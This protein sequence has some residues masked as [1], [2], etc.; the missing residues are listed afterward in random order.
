MAH[1]TKF[2]MTTMPQ[3]LAH[4]NRDRDT[5]SKYSNQEIDPSKTHLNT[6][7]VQGDMEKLQKRLDEVSHTHRKD[8]VVC[9][10]VVVTLPEEL[11]GSG[12]QLIQREFFDECQ[13]F[14]ET[15]FGKENTV[16]SVI[17]NDETTPHLH[18]G[19]VPVVE[20]ERK[21]R[22]KAK[23]GQTYTEKRICVH[24]VVTKPMLCSFHDELQA[25]ISKTFPDVRIV[26]EDKQKR[27]KQN[28]SIAELKE[29][30]EKSLAAK[31]WQIEQVYF[32][33]RQWNREI[34]YRRERLEKD[35]E[36]EMK[37]KLNA[38]VLQV[39]KETEEE[40]A[41]IIQKAHEAAEKIMQ[42]AAKQSQI[43]LLQDENE[44][45]KDENKKLKNALSAALEALTDV[46]TYL[47]DKTLKS[48]EAVGI[49]Y[50]K[51]K[52]QSQGRSM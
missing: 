35:V 15:K 25:H 47:S 20:K 8:L 17:H 16:Y 49:K 51:P 5:V 6:E 24:D 32:E 19:F 12:R 9:C 22:S 18:F 7:L 27:K 30:T 34:N 43:K 44:K 37:D 38:K 13:K 23:Q 3:M 2:K 29:E 31:S 10:G 28:K 21:Y 41:Q 36:Q 48:L 26:A 39:K 11:K 14:L 40:A 46:W 50:V 33:T 52:S 4:I 1:I 45:L 42:E